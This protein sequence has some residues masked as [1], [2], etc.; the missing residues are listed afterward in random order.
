MKITATVAKWCPVSALASKLGRQVLCNFDMQQSRLRY[1]IYALSLR[2]MWQRLSM[3]CSLVEV[4]PWLD[5]ID[6]ESP[7]S[8][9]VRGCKSLWFRRRPWGDPF[10]TAD[11]SLRPLRGRS[12]T[13]TP[14]DRRGDGLSSCRLPLVPLHLPTKPKHTANHSFLLKI[15][16]FAVEA[17]PVAWYRRSLRSGLIDF[18]LTR[19]LSRKKVLSL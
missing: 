11:P 7:A 10:G 3:T 18:W 17:K 4:G 15:S 5:G 16:R 2:S 1:I 9:W 6:G 13:S 19:F 14:P 8:W 12:G